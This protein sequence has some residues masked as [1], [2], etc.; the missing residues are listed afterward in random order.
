[1]EPLDYLQYQT[2]FEKQR[3][4]VGER[5]WI[6]PR[7]QYTMGGDSFSKRGE[8]LVD[9]ISFEEDRSNGAQRILLSIMDCVGDGG[10]FEILIDVGRGVIEWVDD[11]N[12]F[13]IAFTIQMKDA[14]VAYGL[15]L[16]PF[17]RLWSKVPRRLIKDVTPLPE[18]GSVEDILL[19]LL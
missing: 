1:M 13:A 6:N 8:F 7:W 4:Q 15:D 18:K 2:V 5:K 17:V 19:G 11:E 3:L 12:D 16:M 10:V 14:M 9:E